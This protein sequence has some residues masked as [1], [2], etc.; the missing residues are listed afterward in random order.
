MIRYLTARELALYP[1]L[2][3]TMFRDRATQ[4][5][6]RLGWAV[7]VNERGEERD[8]YD[9][10]ES[11]YVIWERADGTHG[12]SMRFRPTTIPTMVNEHFAFL[13]EDR[14]VVSPVIWECTRF[15]LAPDAETR[16][17]SA[18]MLAGSELGL[19]H[20]LSH[21]VGVFDRRMIRVYRR[22]GWGP[23]L[24]G[25]QGEGADQVSLGLW[26]FSEAV[27]TRL[28]LGAGISPALSRHWFDRA[29]GTVELAQ[30]G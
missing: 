1:R 4:F 22:L 20:G 30:A 24:L 11:L 8:Q 26:E 15:C 16:V 5:S 25:T 18:L 21:A 29:F 27:H 23:I 7:T 10:P 6:D 2:A 3:G 14:P 19:G 17:S 9:T 28:A 12:G 13:N